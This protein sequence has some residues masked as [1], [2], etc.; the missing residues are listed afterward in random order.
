MNMIICGLITPECQTITCTIVKTVL[1]L[2][3]AVRIGFVMIRH[4]KI[5]RIN[6]RMDRINGFVDV[7]K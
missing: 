2:I 3:L 1:L 4:H 7:T 6:D 5:E